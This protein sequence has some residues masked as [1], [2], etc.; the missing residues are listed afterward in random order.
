MAH[1]VGK[2]DL[3]EVASALRRLDADAVGGPD[4]I[5]A[6]KSIQIEPSQAGKRIISTGNRMLDPIMEL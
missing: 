4:V 6:L 5:A 3:S 1:Q 2:R